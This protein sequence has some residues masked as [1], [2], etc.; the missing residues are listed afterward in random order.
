MAGCLYLVWSSSVTH[1][2]LQ[3]LG[4][5]YIRGCTWYGVCHNKI[6]ESQTNDHATL[7]CS[8]TY[9]YVHIL[10]HSCGLFDL[11]VWV[12]CMAFLGRRVERIWTGEREIQVHILYIPPSHTWLALDYPFVP[13]GTSALRLECERSFGKDLARTAWICKCCTWSRKT[14][15][16]LIY[17]LPASFMA[18][19]M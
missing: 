2:P 4:N 19:V 13:I 6:W 12:P 16:V 11:C 15:Q 9:M 1:S 7:V 17:R 3:R 10:V 5:G 8:C 14:I 18:G